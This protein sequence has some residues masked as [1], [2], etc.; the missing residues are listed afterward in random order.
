MQLIAT[1]DKVLDPGLY[2]LKVQA[3]EVKAGNTIQADGSTKAG[4]Y[5]RWTFDVIEEGFEGDIIRANSSTA[6]GPSAKGRIWAEALMG[7][8]LQ[9]NEPVDTDDLVGCVAAATLGI[10]KKGDKTYNEIQALASVRRKQPQRA[11]MQQPVEDDEV[12]F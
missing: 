6:F 9:L 4:N 10:T 3:I 2:R 11:Q 5:L 1:E 7:R 12:P 8:T